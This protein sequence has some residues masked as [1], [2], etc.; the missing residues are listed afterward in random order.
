MRTR[1]RTKSFLSLLGVCLAA[2]WAVACGS[3][4]I[5][6]EISAPESASG[7]A[8]QGTVTVASGSGAADV[9]FGAGLGP[10]TVK[11][12]VVGSGQSTTTDK[13]GRFTLTGL[14]AGTATLRFQTTATDARLTLGGLVEGQVLTIDVQVS[15]SDARL[16]SDRDDH[17]FT[18]TVDAVGGSSLVVSGTT[19]F[20]N[21][22][23]EIKRGNSDIALAEVHVGDTVKVQGERNGDG[24]VLAREIKVLGST[25]PG[26]QGAEVEFEGLVESVTPP[27]LVVSGR[28]VLTDS[29][30]DFK[31]KGKIDSVA[32]LNVGDVVEVVGLQSSPSLVL[33]LEIKR[34]E[35]AGDDDDEDDDDDDDDEEDEDEDDD[36][37][38]SGS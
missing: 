21:G 29:D 5:T 17:E 9:G 28:D 18:G 12:S 34:L 32:D 24:T 2:A 6:D 8:I 35:T 25:V 10:S 36:D 15:G 33:A 13:Q 4:S 38:G 16:V 30:T 14:S 26:P 3:G 1:L 37:S 19:V 7:A 31:G 23:T 11:V 20:T 22:M 27:S